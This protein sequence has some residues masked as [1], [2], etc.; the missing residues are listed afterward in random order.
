MNR[1]RYGNPLGLM[2]VTMGF[3]FTAF[4]FLAFRDEGFYYM[5]LLFGILVC[6]AFTATYLLLRL[7]S[8]HI[9]RYLLIVVF[10][11]FGVG[12]IVQYRM[13]T[14]VAYKQMMWYGVGVACMLPV[15]FFIKKN[16]I[17]QKLT[18][19]I[20]I[21]SVGLL[22]VLLFIGRESGGAKNWI[23]VGGM[24]FQPS[25]LVKLAVVLVLAAYL[26]KDRDTK[27]LLPAMIFTAICVILL[28]LERD[29]GA[30][31]LMMGV[32]LILYFTGTGNVKVT[33]LCLLV[34]C[35]GAV[36]SY[37]VFDH[38]RARVTV[39]LDPWAS[40][41]TSGYQIAQGLMA[42]A[43]GGL[44]GLG[45]T[46]GSPKSIPAYQTDYIF[47]VICEEF[48]I[49]FG[50]AIIALYLVFIVRGALIALNAPNRFLMLVAFGCTTLITLQSFIIIG[51]VIKLIPL[52]GITLPFVSY[53][54]SSLVASMMLMGI[55]QGVAMVTGDRLETA[56]E[57]AFEEEYDE[58]GEEES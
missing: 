13:D 4:L 38:V 44:L 47:A 33:L 18:I 51:G 50:I 37:F 36:A 22:G 56:M 31:L 53:G 25:E 24:N 41:Y 5:A 21:L 34:G 49:I 30:A 46:F 1:I 42:I 39:W 8:R 19:P 35:L 15:L 12:M 28:V 11:L 54:G 17:L 23:V 2:L 55:L 16:T 40:Y 26:S 48:G 43:S 27:T 57:E 32:F 10:V 58:E 7:V 29:L 52:T 6:A 45:L 20:M 9:D 14:E 3:I